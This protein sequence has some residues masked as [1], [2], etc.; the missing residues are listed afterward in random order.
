MDEEA[1]E[2]EMTTVLREMTMLVADNREKVTGFARDAKTRTSLG[3]TSATVARN[4]RT[5]SLAA[6]AVLREEAEEVVEDS[7]VATV[8]RVDS[9]TDAAQ[10][11]A[12][13]EA[14]RCVVL[15][16]VAHQAETD[17]DHTKSLLPP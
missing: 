17:N 3:E 13:S 11:E 10:I 4:Q 16:T 6:A 9:A 15:M 7:K 8:V 14:D 1:L 5:A 12:D 2:V